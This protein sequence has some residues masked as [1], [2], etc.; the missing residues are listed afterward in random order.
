[1]ATRNAD[2]KAKA[3]LLFIFGLGGIGYQQYTHDV[4]LILLVIFT[5]MAGLPTVATL[6]S[7]VRNSPIVIPS[8]SSPPPDLELESENSSPDS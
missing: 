3:W 2:D 8:S 6:L 4:D 5:S 1:V 7:L